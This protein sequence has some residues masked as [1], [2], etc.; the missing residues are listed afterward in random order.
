MTQHGSLLS[1]KLS[2]AETLAFGVTI[3]TVVLW[4]S[5]RFLSKEDG[6][7]LEG[8]VAAI[9]SEISQIKSGMSNIAIDVSY[10]RGRIEPKNKQGE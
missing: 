6:S 8:R 2:L 9:E 7:K 1:W 5:D 4:L 10:I 3:I